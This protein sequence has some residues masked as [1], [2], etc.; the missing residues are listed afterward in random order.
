MRIELILI[1]STQRVWHQTLSFSCRATGTFIWT[2]ETLAFIKLKSVGSL[3]GKL[4]IRIRKG[5]KS[6]EQN[7][8]TALSS[9]QSSFIHV[10]LR[11]V[12]FLRKQG[13]AVACRLNIRTIVHFTVTELDICINKLALFSLAQ[14]Y[15]IP[16]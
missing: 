11:V 1:M 10:K 15:V 12:S 5:S 3:T 9:G 8:W 7:V 14:W 6:S 16:L 2:F 13:V 4:V